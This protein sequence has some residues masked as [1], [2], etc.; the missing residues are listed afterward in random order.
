M[1]MNG[2]LLHQLTWNGYYTVWSHYGEYILFERRLGYFSEIWDVYSV[3]IDGT[4]ERLVYQVGDRTI[5]MISDVS[6]SGEHILGYESIVYIN[7]E[8]KLSDTDLEIVKIHLETGKKMYL[9]DNELNDGCPRY[10]SDE[11]MI[12]YFCI[13]IPGE[14]TVNNIENVY[15]MSSDGSNKRRVTNETM[16]NEMGPFLAWSPDGKK[17]AYIKNN[18]IFIVDIISGNVY[19]L[20]NTAK[21][22]IRNKVM[23]WK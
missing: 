17:I 5:F 14:V 19:N 9:T 6:A 2:R 22:S 20:T 23:D 7:D 16:P 12:A 4:D 8:G 10:N 21:D 13:D 3:N 15:V 1:D 11:T 18:D